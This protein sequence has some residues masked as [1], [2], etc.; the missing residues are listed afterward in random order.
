M[1][2]LKTI[3]FFLN[4]FSYPAYHQNN[5]VEISFLHS[6]HI[7]CYWNR[8]MTSLLCL[9]V[10]FEMIQLVVVWML[11]VHLRFYEFK[12]KKNI[13]NIFIFDWIYNFTYALWW[14]WSF[15]YISSNSVLKSFSEFITHDMIQKWIH[16]SGEKVSN[17][18]NIGKVNIYLKNLFIIIIY[19]HSK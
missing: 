14:L 18:R 15:A 11:V 6:F 16:T 1:L 12:R 9:L 8:S 5:H 10:S 17:S 7:T 4:W 13:Y 3:V 19:I 2:E